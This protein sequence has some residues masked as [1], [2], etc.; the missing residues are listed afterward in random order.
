MLRFDEL[1]ATLAVSPAQRACTLK[2][3]LAV[4]LHESVALDVVPSLT[5]L[6]SLHVPPLRDAYSCTVEPFLLG[7][8]EALR[9]TAPPRG[10][11]VAE[12]LSFTETFTHTVASTPRPRP[13]N[14]SRVAPRLPWVTKICELVANLPA[15]LSVKA[16]PTALPVL[17]AKAFRSEEHT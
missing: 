10:T 9:V 6:T 2:E 15:G 7:A 13:G 5:L 11:M 17:P 4:G 8:T 16:L 3:P 14:W 1:L 12:A